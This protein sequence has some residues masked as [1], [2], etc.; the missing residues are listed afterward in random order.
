MDSYAAVLQALGKRARELRMLRELRQS[1]LAAR[2]G[3]APGTV[4]RFERTGR[5][6]IENVLRI[7]SVLGADEGFQTLFALPRYRTLD[8]ALARPAAA[9]RQRV[10]TRRRG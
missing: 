6:S 1:E 10:R 8:E 3:L 4:Q 2:A 9:R 5:A 7:A